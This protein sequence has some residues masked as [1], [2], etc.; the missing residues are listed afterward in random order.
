MLLHPAN[1]NRHPNRGC[2]ETSKLTKHPCLHTYFI[3]KHVWIVMWLVNSGHVTNEGVVDGRVISVNV[4]GRRWTSILM[5]WSRCIVFVSCFLLQC[6]CTTSSKC[7]LRFQGLVSWKWA[8]LLKHS[9][10]ATANFVQWLV[11]YI[12]FIFVGVFIRICL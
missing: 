1:W 6:T 11:L 8:R 7:D 9:F 10:S 12:F 5:T 4:N 3:W 2:S